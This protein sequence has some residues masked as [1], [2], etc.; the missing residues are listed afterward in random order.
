MQRIAF[1]LALAIGATWAPSALAAWTPPPATPP[2]CPESTP[3]CNVPINVS[4]TAQTKRG[5]FYAGGMGILARLGSPVGEGGQLDL[6]TPDGS[7]FAAIDILNEVLRIMAVPGKGITV[8]DTVGAATAFRVIGDISA[9]N[10]VW[11]GNYLT[12]KL[13]T[14]TEWLTAPKA[15]IGNNTNYD[16]NLVVN[17]RADVKGMGANHGLYVDNWLRAKTFYLGNAPANVIGTFVYQNGSQG[18]NKVLASDAGG[19]ATW[20]TLSEIGG[21]AGGGF[22]ADR[23]NGNISNSNAGNV[24]IGTVA[25]T[26]KL[27]VTGDVKATG[28]ITGA[29][30]VS[31]KFVSVGEWIAAP[32][33]YVG[34]ASTG[35][36]GYFRFQNGTQGANKLL[37][38]D[39][40]GNATWK[41]LNEIP[42][43][44][45][46]HCGIFAWGG[47]SEIQNGLI[48][49]VTADGSQ[50]NPYV[51]CP[52]GFTRVGGDYESSDDSQRWWYSCVYTAG[53]SCSQQTLSNMPSNY[54]RGLVCR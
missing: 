36:T 33:A 25:P 46:D 11:V 8:H 6:F 13:V 48:P 50:Y 23:G 3:G 24:G 39:A 38:S 40:S 42:R 9:T 2:T 12:G 52:N 47:N 32:I 29:N 21:S 44:P 26:V 34:D 10:N 15:F 37:A 28:N 19:Q 54:Q 30:Y 18:L 27:D 16:G 22:W 51:S 49:C 1:I 7:K 14:A 5:A 35:K 43:R 31:G 4:A 41:N 45:G 17:G 20:K 53:M